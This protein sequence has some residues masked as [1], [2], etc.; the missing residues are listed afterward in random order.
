MKTNT[1]IKAF[2]LIELMTTVAIVAVMAAIAT[3]S[4]RNMILNNRLAALSNDFISSVS[5]ARNEAISTRE[6]VVIEPKNKDDNWTN[7]WV[8]FIDTD[9]DGS[10]D[11]DEEIIKSVDKLSSSLTQQAGNPTVNI[12]FNSK[13]SMRDLGGWGTLTICDDRGAGRSVNVEG[14]GVVSV[15]KHKVGE[16]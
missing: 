15:E 6:N 10:Y 2:T 3:P 13:G 16:C 9:K 7:G 8:V 11:N 5:A 12:I 14:A 4:L 1:K